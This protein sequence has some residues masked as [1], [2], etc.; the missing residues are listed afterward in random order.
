MANNALPGRMIVMDEFHYHMGDDALRENLRAIDGVP[1]V[2]YQVQ[3]EKVFVFQKLLQLVKQNNH[4]LSLAAE[5]VPQAMVSALEAVEDW[6][7]F[8][9]PYQR[10]IDD[11]GQSLTIYHR[12]FKAYIPRKYQSRDECNIDAASLLLGHHIDG[13]GNFSYR[14]QQM[15]LTKPFTL[16]GLPER[17]EWLYK[18]HDGR[19][20][21]SHLWNTNFVSGFAPLSESLFTDIKS[22]EMEWKKDTAATFSLV[23][24]QDNTAALWARAGELG[25]DAIVG[26]SE[27]C[28]E[29]DPVHHADFQALYPELSMLPPAVIQEAYDD[30][31]ECMWELP[32]RDEEFLFYL[33]GRTASTSDYITQRL[34]KV[35]QAELSK[36]VMGRCDFNAVN[37]GKLI[38]YSLLMG[39]SVADAYRAGLE[40]IDFD[41]AIS[42]LAYEVSLV[43]QYLDRDA[44]AKG[45]E[46]NPVSTLTENFRQMRKTG[47]SLQTVKQS[48]NSFLS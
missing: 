3:G 46:G 12:Y 44:A 26:I 25:L 17:P 14:G 8:P 16:D 45:I 31:L 21:Y 39:N 2:S 48:G 38:A 34:D 41:D 19:Y 36:L 47:I 40:A 4:D 42:T 29:A 15:V 20:A 33:I 35:M 28:Q 13:E 23:S 30:Y 1:G 6:S 9:E 27:Y 22:V 24:E 18:N 10:S 5:L 7:V 37:T 32:D 43:M 11:N